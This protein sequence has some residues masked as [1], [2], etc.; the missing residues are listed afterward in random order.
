MDTSNIK[1]LIDSAIIDIWT[2]EISKDYENE[3]LLQEDPLKCSIY[4]HLRNRLGKI[5]EDNGIRI[6]TEFTCKPFN[7]AHKRP[8]IVIAKM[9]LEEDCGY[10][11]ETVEEII[12][13]IEVKFK[14]GFS[15]SRTIYDDYEKMKYYAQELDIDAKLYMATIWEYEDDPTAWEENESWTK[16]RLTELNASY[17]RDS[18]YV[19]QFYVWRH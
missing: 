13:V 17:I 19:M 12:A 14:N 11:G 16:G 7:D 1:H 3:W 6:Y 10:L 18:D 8:D 4:F 9:K 2:K 5:F 15:S